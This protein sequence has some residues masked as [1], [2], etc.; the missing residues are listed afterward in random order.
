[1][2]S[3]SSLLED[4]RV[5]GGRARESHSSCVSLSIA[6][7]VTQRTEMTMI[8]RCDSI[9]DVVRKGMMGITTAAQRMCTKACSV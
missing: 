6:H 3:K 1:M 5:G 9:F 2:L 8:L 4:L 7:G